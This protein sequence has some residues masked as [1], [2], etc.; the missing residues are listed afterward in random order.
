[1]IIFFEELNLKE[2][3]TI[4]SFLVNLFKNSEAFLF[5]PVISFAHR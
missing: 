4:A 5:F 3:K 1:M 2:N